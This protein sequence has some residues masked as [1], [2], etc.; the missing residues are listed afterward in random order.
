MYYINKRDEDGGTLLDERYEAYELAKKFSVEKRG[1]WA[2]VFS[3]NLERYFVQ[4]IEKYSYPGGDEYQLLSSPGGELDLVRV[5]EN[6]KP[7]SASLIY[8]NIVFAN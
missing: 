4:K 3:V 1:I 8:N 7:K 6:G 5:Y 2:A